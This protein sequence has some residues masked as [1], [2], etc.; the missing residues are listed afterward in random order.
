MKLEIGGGTKQRGDGWVNMD[1]VSSA[2][3][4]HDLTVRPWPVAD[5]SCDEV[6]SSHCIEHVPNILAFLHE[7]VRVGK[8]GCRVEIRCP[9]TSS[10]LAMVD[11]H[12]HV[13]SPM[14]AIN[15]EKYFPRE[16]W[17]HAKRLRL[18][19]HH[20]GSAVLLDQAK[21]ELPFLRGLDDQTIMRWVP[22]TAHETVFSYEVVANEY[23]S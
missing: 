4:V 16:F 23:H 11:T 13:F 22:R 1:Q 19:G 18:L 21:A 2:D 17:P 10:D 5:D 6:Y 15:M 20:F 9:H 8:I 12:V 7:I 14:Q 3:I